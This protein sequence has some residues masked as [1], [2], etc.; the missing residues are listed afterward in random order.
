M[1][2]ADKKDNEDTMD[3]P[4]QIHETLI[5]KALE[6]QKML[7]PLSFPQGFLMKT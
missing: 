1:S 4:V 7:G 2:L 3:E 6:E 5:R